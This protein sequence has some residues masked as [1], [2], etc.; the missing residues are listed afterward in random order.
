MSA[1]GVVIHQS[2]NPAE[3]IKIQLRTS[4]NI[5]GTSKNIWYH[6]ENSW[7]PITDN[8]VQFDE[9]FKS[10]TEKWCPVGIG[11]VRPDQFLDHLTV[12][13]IHCV[14]FPPKFCIWSWYW[15]WGMDNVIMLDPLQIRDERPSSHKYCSA[16]VRP[17]NVTC[18]TRH[19]TWSLETI[20]I[21]FE[22]L[23]LICISNHPWKAI[24]QWFIFGIVQKKH[25]AFE[26]FVEP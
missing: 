10:L 8:L 7:G 16:S 18:R 6:P 20:Q 3:N 24:L 2:Y 14:S 9:D 15:Y 21:I 19:P 17:P 26:H 12:I 25:F 4:E 5:Y 22:H 23:V 11:Y 1:Q 13:K